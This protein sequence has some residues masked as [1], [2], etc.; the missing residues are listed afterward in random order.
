MN[1]QIIQDVA[2][3]TGIPEDRVQ[4]I[5]SSFWAFV[6]ETIQSLPLKSDTLE[7]DLSREE[8]EK[9]RT[10]INIPSL[11]KFHCTYEEYVRKRDCL[12]RTNKIKKC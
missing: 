1:S 11:G 7:R 3:R 8:F 6:R 12:R 9:L 2:G 4:K 10:N 5:Y